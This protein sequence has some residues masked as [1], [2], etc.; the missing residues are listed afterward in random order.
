MRK[1]VICMAVLFLLVLTGCGK[2]TNYDE[3]LNRIEERLSA[4]ESML[5]ESVSPETTA[6]ENSLIGVWKGDPFTYTFFA[7]E[8]GMTEHVNGIS[9]FVYSTNGQNTLIIK[10]NESISGRYE[11]RYSIEGDTLT[12][13]GSGE[14]KTFTRQR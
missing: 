6:L 10:Y 1:I 8:S 13:T 2:E 5:A 9:Y 11:F 3:R 7:D 4:I 14:R 12:L